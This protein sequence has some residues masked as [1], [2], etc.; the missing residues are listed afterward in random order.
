MRDLIESDMIGFGPARGDRLRVV[1][2]LVASYTIVD[3]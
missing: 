2:A 1:T 3:Y